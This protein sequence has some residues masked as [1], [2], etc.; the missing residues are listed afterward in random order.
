MGGGTVAS[1]MGAGTTVGP[2]AMEAMAAPATN[3]S[4]LSTKQAVKMGNQLMQSQQQPQ[5]PQVATQ[6]P[7]S[8]QQP[9]SPQDAQF[10]RSHQAQSSPSAA[11]VMMLK[12]LGLLGVA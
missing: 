11:Q 3:S 4:L 2:L 5:Q 7:P 12:R 9:D 10:N 6:R 1:A 8:M